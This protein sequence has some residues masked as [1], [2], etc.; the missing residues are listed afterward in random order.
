MKSLEKDRS[1]RY[2]SASAFASDI[3]RYLND[4]PVLACPPT[5]MYRF[6]KFARKHKASLTTAAAIAVCLIL[7]TTVS[8]WQA[9]RAKTAESQATANEQKAVANEQKANENAAAAEQ[10]EQEAIKQRDEVK[11]LADK[12]AAK[13]EHLQDTVYADH[14]HMA[15]AA[16]DSGDVS[17]MSELLNQHLP[18][19]G[20]FDRRGFEWQYL[21]RLSKI[22]PLL[23]INTPTSP[24]TQYQFR[25]S[26]D[27]TR[28]FR[29]KAQGPVRPTPARNVPAT[30][31]TLQAWNLQTGQEEFAV[32][33]SS[34]TDFDASRW[35]KMPEF[36]PDGGHVVLISVQIDP[37]TK[38]H[39]A[40]NMKVWDTRTGKE[41]F[42]L[43]G[44][45]RKLGRRQD[46]KFLAVQME[47]QSVKIWDLQTGQERLTLP[48][49]HPDTVAFSPDGKRLA[50]IY[51]DWDETKKAVAE[52]EVKICD[53]QTGERL[54]AFKCQANWINHLVFSP[55]GQHL[56]TSAEENDSIKLWD[57]QTGKDLM[58][59]RWNIEAIKELRFNADGTRLIALGSF[60]NDS[61]EWVHQAKLWNVQSGQE[62][63]SVS[64]ADEAQFSPDGRRV[65]IT[66]GKRVGLSQP[67]NSRTKVFDVKSGQIMLSVKDAG[68]LVAFSPD[69]KRLATQSGGM[70]VWDLET[71]DE[72]NHIKGFYGSNL[73]SFSQDGQRLIGGAWGATQVW[74]VNVEQVSAKK[75]LFPEVRFGG[76]GDSPTATSSDFTRIAGISKIQAFSRKTIKLFDLQTGQELRTFNGH[77]ENVLCVAF[78][79]D[80]KRV[81]SGD[82]QQN[83]PPGRNEAGG[84][85]KVWGV[86]TGKE[87]FTIANLPRRVLRLKFSPDGKKLAGTPGDG[88]MQLWDAHS[89]LELFGLS[90]KPPAGGRTLEFAFSSDGKHLA[91]QGK[92]WD[93]E[94]GDELVMLKNAEN[95]LRNIDTSAF[96]P[97]GKRVAGGAIVGPTNG[98]RIIGVWDAETGGLLFKT[99]TINVNVMGR[100][101]FSPDGNRLA[102]GGRIW[103]AHTGQFLL[104]LGSDR[105]GQTSFSPDGHRLTVVKDYS[106]EVTIYDATP[107]PNP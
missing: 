85:V 74:D 18:K 86:E 107:L 95:S 71:G 88:T 14:I 3:H 84:S 24:Y 105:G 65:A 76:P 41:V 49:Q 9:V 40:G 68:G 92:I 12:L 33:L 81:A 102:S 55:D 53:L 17:T 11:A 46:N 37:A 75:V 28:L 73:L 56:V 89:G 61:K 97:D 100:P 6:E 25:L 44:V 7:G 13:D 99:P 70:R 48:D 1:R 21:N 15:K 91:W 69:S 42:K 59:F 101:T 20:E 93:A 26:P 10:K 27:R 16:W 5:A 94:T 47:S 87:L 106:H 38:K 77:K 58:T 79:P 82:G 78:S 32:E 22:G 64:G 50:A 60:E 80:G 45:V 52:S 29:L 19:A 104:T 4:E 2:E 57:V 67:D 103:D 8:A 35:G 66:E 34:V 36:T 83:D 39:V 54:T 90:T 23:S 63:L 98:D 51:S 31:P 72:I 96:S 62:L 30:P 43:N